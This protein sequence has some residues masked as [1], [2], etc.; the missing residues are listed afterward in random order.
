MQAE[1]TA[2]ILAE[3]YQKTVELALA[4]WKQR[5]LLFF[6][7]LGVI[8]AAT[9]LAFNVPQADSILKSLLA[10]LLK[11]QPD[12]LA[13][14]PVAV[15]QS[16][17]LLTVFFFV[18]NLY[19]AS[20]LVRKLDVYLRELEHEI[21]V[22][23]GLQSSQAFT[24]ESS[25]NTGR[26]R[27]PAVFLAA[28]YVASLGI[29]LVASLGGQIVADFRSH[30]ILLGCVDVVIAIATLLYFFLYAHGAL[31]PEKAH[32]QPPGGRS[33]PDPASS[34]QAMSG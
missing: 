24:R 2:E 12:D 6:V 18:V 32:W 28:T 3:H 33:L 16:A 20:L 19:Q 26:Q 17:L 7:L 13:D 21:R 8:S 27:K 22:Q 29:F 31:W 10:R 23:L 1:K 5:N 4:T 30:K 14:F 34:Q 15:I 11:V 25:H 9:L